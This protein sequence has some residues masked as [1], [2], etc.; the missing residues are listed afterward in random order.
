MAAIS[1]VHDAL[2]GDRYKFVAYFQQPHSMD[3]ARRIV[4]TDKLRYWYYR[5]INKD[6]PFGPISTDVYRF[7]MCYWVERGTYS[8]SMF[9]RDIWYR[10]LVINGD[11]RMGPRYRGKSSASEAPPIINFMD[12]K[13]YVDLG[14][15]APLCDP[16]IEDLWMY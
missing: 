11:K 8:E 5:F 16:S 4:I 9:D 7:L 10:A 1:D 14:V 3:T 13:G 6:A 15:A 12:A 2:F